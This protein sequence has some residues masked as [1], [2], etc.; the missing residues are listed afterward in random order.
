MFLFRNKNY[1]VLSSSSYISLYYY[2]KFHNFVKTLVTVVSE[3][4]I[5]TNIC[6]RDGYSIM[7]N[8]NT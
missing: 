7:I 8:G 1:C 2:N 5:S 3:F 4:A 6:L